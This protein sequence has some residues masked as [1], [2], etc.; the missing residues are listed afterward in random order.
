MWVR[1]R[2]LPEAVDAE[3]AFAALYRDSPYGFW[4]DSSRPGDRQARWSFLG[5]A[6]GPLAQVVTAD[7]WAGTVTVADS[8]GAAEQL[9]MPFFDWLGAHHER[10]VTMADA[11]V[12]FQV[13]WV[14]YL[15]YELKA[16]CGGARAHRAPNPD[17]ALLFADRVVAID[18]ISARTYL[19]ALDDGSG[20]AEQWLTET[21]DRLA[22][23]APAEPPQFGVD[24]TP[25]RLRHGRTEYLQL[26]DRC[27]QAIRVGDSYELCLTNMVEAPAGF[28]PWQAYRR[29]R[30]VAPAPYAAYLRFG[31]VAVLSTS[32]ERFLA[33][34]R[35][36][37]AQ[38]RPI[39]GTR[40]RG[41]DAAED[42]ALAAELAANPKD[43]AENL[44]IVDL[45][46]NDLARVAEPGSVEVAGLFE[47]E[48]YATVHQLVS[49]VQAR[50]RADRTA[51]DCVRAAFPG[52]SMTGAP[53]LRTMELLDELEGGPRGVYSGALGWL[54]VD[55]ALDLAMV[56]RTAVVARGLVSY[57]VGGAIVADSDPVAEYEETA[58]KAT[59]LLRLLGAEFTG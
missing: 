11:D 37:V 30:Q 12:P 7:V 48:T 27:H 10:P 55:G 35:D 21:G 47:V 14:G 16:E 43:R 52:G 33:V 23:L 31:D 3:A 20:T 22:D 57:G 49:T 56:I 46:R 45:V 15:G 6:G 13:G 50:L 8:S 58:V 25:L 42:A 54:G 18:A 2:R 36:G 41:R 32:P 51:V 26:V 1:A 5:D 29:L 4:L 19:F 59:P 44:M 24:A 39:K 28:D 40:P 38:S 53:K 34:G 9:S 17:A